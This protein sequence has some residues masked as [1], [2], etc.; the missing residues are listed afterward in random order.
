[1]AAG[2]AEADGYETTQERCWQRKRVTRA[3]SRQV[4]PGFSH[5]YLCEAMGRLSNKGRHKKERRRQGG[6]KPGLRKRELQK[7]SAGRDLDE[8]KKDKDCPQMKPH[9]GTVEDIY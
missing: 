6:C 9:T 4:H 1:M 3:L 8:E 5:G 2:C 7:P